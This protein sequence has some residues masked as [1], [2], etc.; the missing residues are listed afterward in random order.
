MIS[1]CTTVKNRSLVRVGDHELQ[2]FPN[3]VRSLV[4]AIDTYPCELLVADWE[5]D[6]W[7]LEEWLPERAKPISVQIVSATGTFSRGKGRNLAANA[8]TGKVISFLDADILLPKAFFKRGL[9]S[10]KAGKAFFPILFS[11]DDPEHKTGRWRKRG[12]GNC[13]IT[14]DS[15]EESG[16]WPEYTSWGQEDKAF[17]VKISSAR[18]VSREKLPGLLH[19]WHPDD[20]GWKNR[21][22]ESR[23]LDVQRGKDRKAAK[24]F[25]RET[26]EA[27]KERLSELIPPED[28]FILLDAHILST[29]LGVTR[30]TVRFG[31]GWSKP[32][33]D[34][35][36]I[37]ELE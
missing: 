25:H 35:A 14:R 32:P 21:Y 29:E 26:V 12:F 27:F 36:A 7:P 19:Q 37:H 17:F 1:I 2:L 13:M 10:V 31:E 34:E 11:Y 4:A 16:G 15:F 28:D 5:S 22:G 3:F 33:D 18:P 30:R 24:R 23:S 8:A 6:D 9:Q 20:V